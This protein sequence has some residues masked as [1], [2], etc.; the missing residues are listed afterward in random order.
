MLKTAGKSIAVVL[1]LGITATAWAAAALPGSDPQVRALEENRSQAEQQAQVTAPEEAGKVQGEQKFMLTSFNFT[2]QEAIDP[3]IFTDLTKD[4]TGREISV[5]ELQQAADVITDYCRSQGYTVATAF[6]PQQD[7]QNGV[8]EIRVLLGTLGE[9]RIDNQSRL[10][11]EQAAS[12]LSSL[13]QGDIIKNAPLE[14]ALNNLNDLPGIA[15]AG[16]LSA[17][18]EVGSTDLTVTL[19]DKKQ[20][21][22]VLYTDNHGGQYSGRYRYG[23]QTTMNNPGGYGDKFFVGGM[24]TNSDLHNYNLGYEMPVGSS[25]SRLG[26]SY[27]LM[28]YTLSGFYNILDAV[29]RAKTF[30]IYGS[31]PIV[32]T[33]S[34]YLAAAYGYDNRQLQDELRTFGFNTKKHSDALHLGIVGN[35]RGAGSYTGYSALYYAGRLTYDDISTSNEGTYHKFNTDVNHIQM[36]GHAVNLHVNLHSQLASKDLDGSEQFSLGGADGVRAYPQG[37]ASGSVGYQ[38]TAELRYATPITNLSL[39]T[40]IDWGEVE[41]SKNIGERRNLAGWGIGVQYAKPNDYYLRVDYAKKINGEAYQSEEND[42]NGRIWF[43]AYKL[44]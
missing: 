16:I 31:T 10:S 3:A 14:T 27:S 34:N 41:V 35:S 40:F 36:L 23:F 21:D 24:L 26:V 1:T 29:G 13:H 15:A 18:T 43:L 9:V 42:K 33:S 2:G 39:A 44:F 38:A 22:T 25:G 30:S 4:Y 20:F 7:I 11:A 12:F 6:L 37:E 28:D 17:G 5:S 19:A 8:V 32:N